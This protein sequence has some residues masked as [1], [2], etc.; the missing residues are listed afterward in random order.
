MC[1]SRVTTTMRQCTDPTTGQNKDLTAAEMIDL[2]QSGECHG[3]MASSGSKRTLTKRRHVLTAGCLAAAGLACLAPAG[4]AHAGGARASAGVRAACHAWTGR[5]PPYAIQLTAVAALSPCDIWAAG[6]PGINPTASSR[7]DVLHWNGSRWTLLTSP[8]VPVSLAPYPSV[9]ATAAGGAWVAGSA[10]GSA[11]PQAQ[12]LLAHAGTS[13][14]TRVASPNPGAPRGVNELA[15]VSAA[16]PRDA[17]AVGVYSVFDP[18]TDTSVARPL[19]EHWNGRAWTQVPAQVPLIGPGTPRHPTGF[20][21][22]T[23]VTARHGYDTWAVGHYNTWTGPGHYGYQNV[24]LAERWNGHAWTQVPSPNPAGKSHTQLLGVSADGRDDAWMVGVYNGND[25][26]LPGRTLAEH[27]NGKSWTIVPTPNPG[28]SQGH[29]SGA[30]LGVAAISPRNAWAV[31]TYS[32]PA[33]GKPRSLL[34]HWNGK[35]WRQ[36][37]VPHLGPAGRPNVLFAVS[38]SAAGNVIAVGYYSGLRGHEAIALRYG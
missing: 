28:R 4:P 23:A 26:D 36:V 3:P 5:H 32:D 1:N 13:G 21:G 25:G 10:A 33:T 30:L 35:S 38:A 22:F 20:A 29:P 14:L 18:G 19:T 2:I 37:T 9:T 16:G 24:S 15:G 8:S 27:W 17:W 12:T 31:G 6:V 7:T 11:G 34:L